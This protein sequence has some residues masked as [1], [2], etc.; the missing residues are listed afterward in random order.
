MNKSFWNW[1]IVM[2][3]IL[4]LTMLF[5]AYNEISGGK[6]YCQSIEGK[7][8]LHVFPLPIVHSCNGKPIIAYTN[9]W[10]FEQESNNLDDGGLG[11]DITNFTVQI[12]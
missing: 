3:S 1:I 10:R 7:Y 2:G 4:I 12:P 5:V 8:Q 9:G 11:Q 6:E